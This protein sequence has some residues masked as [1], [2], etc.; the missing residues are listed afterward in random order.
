MKRIRVLN[1]LLQFKSGDVF[2]SLA[3]PNRYDR[4]LIP[5]A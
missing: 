4:T 2:A 5:S 3:A 1:F